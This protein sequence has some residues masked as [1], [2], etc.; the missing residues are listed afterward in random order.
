MSFDQSVLDWMLDI[1]TPA[2]T[3]AVTVV[4]NSGG[5][6]AAFV[7]SAVVTITLLYRRYTAEAVMVAG[8][9]LSGWAAMSLLKLLFGRP[10]PPLPERLVMLES[11]SFPSGHA[12]MSA[13]LACVLGAV[14]VRIVAPGVGRILLLAL[15]AC[16]TLAVGL[17]RVYLGAHWLTDVLAGWTFGVAWAALWVW[18]ISRRTARSTR[19]NSV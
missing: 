5:T 19:T 1:R 4:T 13:I 7:I 18:A 2:L 17:S 11:Y 12:M 3:D 10:R 6:V 15:L 9:M 14:V 8:A 16:Y